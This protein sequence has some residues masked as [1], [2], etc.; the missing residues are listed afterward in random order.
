MVRKRK[1]GLN[2]KAVWSSFLIFDKIVAISRERGLCFFS[3]K[4]V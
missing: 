1:T 2:D 4:K 3:F